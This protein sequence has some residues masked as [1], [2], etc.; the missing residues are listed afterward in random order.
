MDTVYRNYIVSLLCVVDAV[1][2]KEEYQQ[3]LAEFDRPN[4]SNYFDTIEITVLGHYQ[5]FTV[6]N[7]LNLI[8]FVHLE[9]KP[10][11]KRNLDATASASIRLPEE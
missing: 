5:L 1:Q 6:K 10:S 2:N 3:L 9:V 4:I 11:I 7:M 8:M